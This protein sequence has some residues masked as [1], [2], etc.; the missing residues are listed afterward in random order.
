MGGHAEQTVAEQLAERISAFQWRDVTPRALRRARRAIIDAI[1]VTLAGAPE[2]CSQILLRTPGV[3]T[4][5]GK[6]LILGA[7]RRTSALDAT[8]VNGTA[9]HALDYDDFSSVF[10]GHP[11]VPLVPLLLAVGDEW[12][13][14]GAQAI[15]AYVIG[16]ETETRIARA[17]HFHHYDKGWHPTATL[18]VFGSAAAASHALRLTPKQT[19]IALAIAASLGSGLKANFGTMT[20]PLHVGHSARSGLLAALLAKGDFTSNTGAFEHH[21]GFLNVYNGPG[22]YDASRIFADW[23]EPLEIEQPTLVLKRFPCCGST[24]SAIIAALTIARDSNLNPK[25]I[26][27][28][29]AL[30]HGRRLRHTD[31]PNPRTPL[32][33][34]FSTQYVVARAL[35]DR[36]VKLKDF[37][38]DAPFDP[39]VRKILALTKAR[40]HP[41]MADDS[42]KQWGAEVIVTLRDGRRLT[43]R[44]ED[45]SETVP[46]ELAS[47]EDSFEKFEDCARLALPAAVVAPLFKLLETLETAPDLSQATR[48]MEV[49]QPTVGATAERRRVNAPSG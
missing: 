20:K 31:N 21:Q 13:L 14:S 29:E 6:A 16:V 49:S 43:H 5:P 26:A 7:D 39:E 28:V 35:V 11:S 19:A 38:A 12:G 48:L 10:G 15:A 4:A 36:A 47:S 23:R 9:S 46:D 1:G 25:D 30:S 37:E 18:G 42:S 27:E 32:E 3:A 40:A 22:T 34:K 44:I 33:A 41:D 45:I 2:R 8:L 24:H 17:V